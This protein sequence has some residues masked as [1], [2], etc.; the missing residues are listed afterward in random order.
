[1]KVPSALCKVL[2]LFAFTTPALVFAQ[3]Q[4]PT[5]EE[6]K[7][8]SDPKAPGAAAVYLYREETTDDHLHFHSYYERIK[9]LTE[10]GKELA[11]QTIPY[12]KGPFKVTDIQGRTIHPDGTIIPL[13]TKAADLTDVK[14]SSIQINKMVF[15]LPDV[16]VGSILEFRLQI[17]YGDDTVVSP[18][19]E[20]QQ[21]Y[22][23]HKAHYFFAP[24]PG[25]GHYIQDNHGNILDRI[26]Y[27][28]HG[29]KPEKVVRDS[30]GRYT[31]DATDVPAI[32]DEDW[33][34]PMNT[35]KWR[36][37]FYYTFARSGTDFWNAEG[38]RWAKEA[39][40]F[41]NPSGELK[42]AVADIVA[43]GDTDPKK[44][45]KI[46]A[47]VM[48][49]DNT[50]FTRRKS[51][52]E[53]KAEKIKEIK[54][55]EDVW[56]QQSGSSDDIA[57][58]YVA[59]ARAAGLKVWPMQVVDRDRAIFDIDYFDTRQLDDYIAVVEID[60]KDVFLDPGEKMCPFGAMHW[61]HAGADGLRLSDKG[62]TIA[63]TPG[64]TYK[65]ASV[66][67]A[68]DI[69]LDEHGAVKGVV[70][71]VMNGPDALYWRQK[72]LQNDPE[73]VKKQFT[74]E[75]RGAMPEGIEAEL[76][77]FIGE[78][79]YNVNLIGVMNVTGNMGTATGK[80]VFLPGL[81]F[82]ARSKHPFAA[83][84]KRQT[85]VD[86]HFARM[87]QEQAIYHLPANFAVESLPQKS[88]L[89]W[90]DHALLKM[91]AGAKD[92]SVIVTRVF[93][94]N[95]SLL[96]DKDYA[97]LHGFYQKIAAADQQQIVLTRT[98]AVAKGN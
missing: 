59:L 50:D 60:G 91:N 11:T 89:N 51:E 90:P 47:A 56:K 46:Y 69:T 68:A 77:H 42:K 13:T 16:T 30:T 76:D 15:T 33:M 86:V 28:V 25:G 73:E 81:F 41:A 64:I 92:G 49:L 7:M 35:L 78:K 54:H 93:A 52:A 24:D 79:D 34:P 19:W 27:Y 12:E 84:E 4:Q 53:R 38:K 80:R 20:V 45:E 96:A 65:Q 85:P 23:V 21:P 26:M 44:A 74:E 3:F 31:Y 58:L 97:D 98:P 17:R 70:R 82:E 32:P 40:H 63:S 66:L 14:T 88:D 62:A 1:M 55:A 18:D 9:I 5:Q 10:K 48:K 75:M 83:Q 71:V 94:H 6:L 67:R 72:M 95:Y 57:L 39:E 36:V 2:L 87:L 8:T 43:P 22:F 29:D 37:Q 61:K